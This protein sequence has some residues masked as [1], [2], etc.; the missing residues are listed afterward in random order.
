MACHRPQPIK[1][2]EDDDE[3]CQFVI[4]YSPSKEEKMMTNQGQTWFT[5]IF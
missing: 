1:R 4:I 2:K 3:F 5:I